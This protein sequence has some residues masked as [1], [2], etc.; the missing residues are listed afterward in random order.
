MSKK[1]RTSLSEYDLEAIEPFNIGGGRTI[2]LKTEFN[3]ASL[4]IT[5]G[6]MDALFFI[7]SLFEGDSFLN[8]PPVLEKLYSQDDRRWDFRKID[9]D[10]IKD[11]LFLEEHRTVV[12][13]AYEL[14]NI[15][16]G[17]SSK[18]KNKQRL[19]TAIK[20]LHQIVLEIDHKVSFN[21]KR[22]RIF[23]SPIESSFIDTETDPC[24]HKVVI[25]FSL[26]FMPYVLAYSGFNKLD[27]RILRSLKTTYAARYYQWMVHDSELKKGVKLS[28][29]EIKSRLGIPE[30]AYKRGFYNR[31]IEEPIRELNDVAG[32]NIVATRIVDK[33]KQGRPLT[34]IHFS[35]APEKTEEYKKLVSQRTKVAEMIMLEDDEDFKGQL[36]TKLEQLDRKIANLKE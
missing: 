4:S 30:G 25:T 32:M 6:Q 5:K 21:S 35:E 33:H 9:E 10:L 12:I 31:V 36:S 7:M 22:K 23:L 16:N 14:N 29:E 11:V 3:Y 20:T 28:I 24:C 26:K 34:H 13:D 2:N 27:L 8:A 18:S 19:E 1:M 17:P 15:I